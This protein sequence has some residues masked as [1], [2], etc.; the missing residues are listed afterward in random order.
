MNRISILLLLLF[1]LNNCS[2]DTKSGFWTQGKKIKNENKN[3]TKI[4]EEEKTTNK[5]FNPDL[6]L[7]INFSKISK[8]DF[9]SLTNNSG[10]SKFNKNIKK[11]SNFKFSKIKNFNYFEPDLV[12]DGK[13][14]I[15][16][17]NNAN[18]L[19]FDSDFKSVWKKNYYKKKE[20]KLKPI[21]TLAISN[22]S[23][24]VTDNIGKIYKVSISSGNLIW[25]KLNSNPFNSQ[26]K[27]YK[28]KIYVID[29]NNIL[30]CFSLKDG[31]EL[32]KFQS[33]NT[34]LKSNK[35][36][37]IAIKNDRIYFNNSLGDLIAVNANN[38]SLIWQIPTQSSSI[39][40]N[41]FGLKMSDLVISGEDLVFSNNRNQFYSINL[42]NGILKWKQNINSSVRPVVID[43]LVFSFSNEGYLF[44]IDK[45]KGD[46][47]RITDVFNRF[48]QKRRN[49]ILPIG[50]IVNKDEIML[51]TNNGRLLIIDISTGKTVS[52]LK[53]DNQQISRPFIF[54]DKILLAKD[55]SI[56]RLD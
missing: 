42:T 11:S 26:I 23:L 53:I 12:S 1:I 8:K 30:R 32:W 50:F 6:N 33:E 36:N 29:M 51:T 38:G 35:R 52:I 28:D 37:S 9:S 48:K 2:L 4:L 56:I 31:S 46:I 43:D 44:I 21:L 25:S 19:K 13:N 22:D 41:S 34:F 14:F 10:L 47:I 24:V 15:F 27:I 55:N 18:L 5:E 45:K 16:F 20:K 7:N 17:D 40:E 39:Y 54:N 49:Q 3:I